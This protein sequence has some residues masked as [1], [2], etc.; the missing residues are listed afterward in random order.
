M[1]SVMALLVGLLGVPIIG[2][3][4]Q[5]HFREDVGRF[6]RT[7][8]RTAEHAVL[9][10]QSYTIVV[11]VEDGYYTV[12]PGNDEDIY[13]PEE[14]ETLIDEQVLDKSY[15]VDVETDDGDQSSLS[16]LWIKVGPGGWRST[17]TL[18]L[19]DLDDRDYFIRCDRETPRVM[20][21]MM[22]EEIPES[23]T[24]VDMNTPL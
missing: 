1:L 24:D 19:K 6:A 4:R 23:L 17:V 12:Y 9:A 15:I 11:E 8:R 21:F 2:R 3:I 18:A 5:A 13:D 14:G 7:L 22:R 20:L 10:G 16:E